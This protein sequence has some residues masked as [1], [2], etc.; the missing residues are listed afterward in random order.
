MTRLVSV[1]VL[2]TIILATSLGTGFTRTWTDRKG[3]QIE[4]ELVSFNNGI[5]TIKRSDGRVFELALEQLSDAD[6]AFV[7]SAR[8]QAV[9]ARPPDLKQ[10]VKS[11]YIVL[12]DELPKE[13]LIAAIRKTYAPFGV[14]IVVGSPESKMPITQDA[15]LIATSVINS[16]R[17]GLN[18]EQSAM[19]TW[20]DMANEGIYYA[21]QRRA[22]RWQNELQQISAPLFLYDVT[23]LIDLRLETHAGFPT[24]DLKYVIFRDRKEKKII[25]VFDVAKNEIVSQ[26]PVQGNY[27]GGLVF[28]DGILASKNDRGLELFDLSSLPNLGRSEVYFGESK[29]IRNVRAYGRSVVVLVDGRLNVIH[30]PSGQRPRI[31]FT[32]SSNSAEFVINERGHLWLFESVKT[33]ANRE[34]F[35]CAILD[36]NGQLRVEGSEPS[37]K[38]SQPAPQLADAQLTASSGRLGVVLDR[39][40][41]GRVQLWWRG[42]KAAASRLCE[43]PLPAR[44]AVRAKGVRGLPQWDGKS[45]N[46]KE[47]PWLPA[48]EGR[49]VNS[50]NSLIL[51]GLLMAVEN[52]RDYGLRRL[53]NGQ[54]LVHYGGTIVRFKDFPIDSK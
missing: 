32:D 22:D 17:L 26:Q 18:K 2:A 30:F 43:F 50:E 4:A 40:R 46:G 24:D 6:R 28:G 11:L 7:K 1:F 14:E 44:T 21:D 35:R 52:D 29:A 54:L 51:V 5:V 16:D 37:V 53:P 34:P 15:A 10:T 23:S 48:N 38:R 9:G 36:S 31:T 47:H 45:L 33:A 3:R 19:Y 41:K 25:G 39:V 42:D 8:S 27:S 13:P 49:P 12:A 20:V